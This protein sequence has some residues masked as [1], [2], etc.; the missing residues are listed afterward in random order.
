MA[1]ACCSGTSRPKIILFSGSWWMTF[2]SANFPYLYQGQLSP[3]TASHSRGFLWFPDMLYK[4]ILSSVCFESSPLFFNKVYSIYLATLS[5]FSEPFPALLYSLRDEGLRTTYKTITWQ[6]YAVD[7][8]HRFKWVTFSPY[9]F[10]FIYIECHLPSQGRIALSL[11][12]SRA[13]H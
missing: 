11:V 6:G 13:W 4:G 10:A 1:T 9:A 12:H 2:S 3:F 8:S 7:L 5:P